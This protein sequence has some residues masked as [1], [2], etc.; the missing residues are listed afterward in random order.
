MLLRIKNSKQ[1]TYSE[2]VDEIKKSLSTY[3]DESFVN[4]MFTH[5]QKF[6]DPKVGVA[7]NFP[8]CCFLAMK[9]KYTTKSK[10]HSKDMSYKKF[11]GVVNQIYHLQNEA[12][13]LLQD[14]KIL[15]SLRRMMINQLLYR[16]DDQFNF[17][18]LTRQYLWYCDSGD[19]WYADSFFKVTNIELKT[20]YKIAFYLSVILSINKDVESEYYPISQFIIHLV[21]LFGIEQ[22]KQFLNLTSLK[23]ERIR[24]FLLPF[25][26]DKNITME[27]YED[28]PMLSRPLILNND[29]LVV[30]S[31]KIMMSGFVN[32]VPELLKSVY[33]EEYKRHFGKTLEDYASSFLRKYDYNF[34]TETDIKRIYSKN[35]MSGKTVDFLIQENDANIYIDC[36]AIEPGKYVKTSNDPNKLRQRLE[37][38]FIKG[39]IQGEE[40]AFHLDKIGIV[41]PSAN[42]A[43]IIIVHRDHYISNAKVVEETIHPGVFEEIKEKFTTLHISPDRIYYTTIDEFE[44][45]LFICKEKNK[46]IN[47]MISY[48]SRGDSEARSQKFNVM[49]HL[50]ELMPEGVKDEDWLINAKEIFLDEIID[51]IKNGSDIW[52]GKASTFLK[53]KQVLMQ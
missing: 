25:K 10:I 7:L 1:K 22:I 8:W 36:K 17:N 31:K 41:K 45:M 32:L 27:Y 50:S 9:W 19:N 49:M 29:G 16:P 5:F 34:I 48:F 47:D 38:S 3:S 18:A 43:M 4:N 33:S 44:K 13:N 6:R 24:E 37:S 12:S 26:L 28:T 2:K 40:C 14:E 52:N 23:P 11:V 30:L 15:L 42:D 21:P 35:K 53:I 39:I 20:F 51:V 46:N